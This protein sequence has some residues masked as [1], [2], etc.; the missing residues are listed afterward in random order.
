MD[1]DATRLAV[2]RA[3]EMIG[4]IRSVV[5]ARMPL[6]PGQV[7]MTPKEMR[8]HVQDLSPQ[9]KEAMIAKVGEQQWNDLMGR[10][11]GAA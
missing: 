7:Q 8:R 1:K 5:K 6:G 10:L 2:E 3:V 4:A 9:A 11:Y